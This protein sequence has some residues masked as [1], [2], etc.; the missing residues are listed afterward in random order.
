MKTYKRPNLKSF[1]Q[2][3]KDKELNN[4]QDKIMFRDITW[5][6]SK[7]DVKLILEK[8]NIKIYKQTGD[9]ILGWCPDHYLYTGRNPSHPKW[10]LNIQTGKTNCFTEGRGSN[11]LRIVARLK[12][13][14]LY[15]AVNWMVGEDSDFEKIGTKNLKFCFEKFGKNDIKNTI[16][17]N[18]DVSNWIKEGVMYSDGYNYFMYPPGKK[19]TLIKKE[20]VDHYHCIQMK[21]GQYINRVIIPFYM[22]NELKGFEA[23][24]ILGKEE[25]IKRHPT[26][27]EYDYKKVLYPSEANGFKRKLCLFG[28]DDIK[29]NSLVIIT[30]GAREVMKLWQLGYSAVSVLGS[31][32]SSEQLNLLCE[33]NPKA[34]LL[35]FDGDDRGIE[36]QRKIGKMLEEFFL[37]SKMIIKRGYDPKSLPEDEV[38]KIIEKN[39]KRLGIY[40]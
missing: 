3:K 28:Y 7:I 31:S 32:M 26:L 29:K 35:M 27:K 21:N 37:V 18:H 16:S 39:K 15:D 1:E 25:W 2:T 14:N 19:P 12:Q 30:E 20:T 13:C 10:S 8:L 36:A 5:L 6:M 40:N 9:E 11:L 23:V 34:V 33:L 22:K 4:H 24:D 17:F 38:R